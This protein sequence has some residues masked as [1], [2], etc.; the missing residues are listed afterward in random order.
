MTE[1]SPTHADLAALREGRPPESPALLRY[2]EVPA[3]GWSA[4]LEREYLRDFIAEGGSKVKLLLGT[5]GSGKSHLLSLCAAQAR[6]AGYVT[7]ELDAYGTRLFPI[8]RL[9]G[10]IVR[11]A[12][13]GSLIEAYVRGVV[14]ELGFEPEALP[15]RGPFLDHALRTG[16]GVEMTLRRGLHER[17]D[18]LLRDPGLDST[19]AAAVVQLVGHRLGVF[20]LSEAEQDALVRW[21]TADKL[22]VSEL[23]SLQIYE[24]ADRYTGRD[25]LRSLAVFA[26]LS[27]RRGLVV[28]VDNLETVAH[29][30]P[31][32][33]RQRYTRLQRDEAFETLRQLIDDVDRS[34]ATLYLLAGRREFLEDEKA[35]I[36]SYEALR[37]R[38]LQEVRSDR[39]NPYADIVD[40]DA[41]RRTGYLSGEAL[42]EWLSRMRSLQGSEEETAPVSP[43]LSLR[44]LVLATTPAGAQA[45][46]ENP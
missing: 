1:P 32:S 43:R 5:P 4:F 11:A 46:A 7:A 10:A 44:Q 9:Y 12:G 23:K 28:C 33:G 14:S 8:D 41:A 13:L 22:R 21:F 24:R 36:S 18:A 27:G 6:E 25:Y 17:V 3:P 29:R 38:L 2:L 35:G 16:M 26:R 39:F 34:T 15:P 42:A 19:F 45:E 30:S 20:R 37:L 40:L 31:Q